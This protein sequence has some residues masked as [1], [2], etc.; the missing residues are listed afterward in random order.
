MPIS[1]KAFFWIGHKLDRL[2]F[3]IAEK[4]YTSLLAIDMLIVIGLEIII[5]SFI[6][7]SMYVKTTDT[8]FETEIFRSYL[9]LTFG[10]GG[11]AVLT[12][13]GLIL[14]QMANNQD[15]TW[16]KRKFNLTAR[17]GILSFTVI[18][19]FIGLFINRTISNNEILGYLNTTSDLDANTIIETFNEFE[20]KILN[21]MKLL[22]ANA[23]EIDQ[24]VEYAGI[25][26]TIVNY[27]DYK[28]NIEEI[29]KE[30][31]VAGLH[32]LR[33]ITKKLALEGKYHKLEV[34]LLR[35]IHILKP[36]FNDYN[37]SHLKNSSTI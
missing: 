23:Q 13:S 30:N 20:T 1:Y 24:Q 19:L 8:I 25:S 9:L 17:T 5:I 15:V 10:I 29:F 6:I 18:F 12:G 36:I 35:S 28:K 31:P 11:Y 14:L 22:N 34:E 37:Y 21:D 2:N 7:S 32:A 27:S 4:I 26:S 16:G 3:K 33:N